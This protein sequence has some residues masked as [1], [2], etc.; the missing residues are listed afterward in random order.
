MN[1]REKLIQYKNITI[2]LITSAENEDYDS[3]DKLLA[4]R[5]NIMDEIDNITYSK[6]EF[7]RLCRELDI[8]VLNQKLIKVTKEKKATILKNIDEL[9]TSKSANK[10]YNKRFSVDSVFFNKKI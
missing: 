1:L 6:E 8:L 10:S 4:N 7:L 9:K 5:Q 3:L 2:Q